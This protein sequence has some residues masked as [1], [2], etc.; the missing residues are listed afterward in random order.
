MKPLHITIVGAGLGGLC[1]AQGLK[2]RGI[3]FDVYERD[4]AL[5]SRTQGYR[6]RIDHAGQQALK[7]CLPAALF[8]VFQSTS[9][10]PV[11]GVNIVDTELEAVSGRWVESWRRARGDA[12]AAAQAEAEA[13][14]QAEAQAE[15][16]SVNRQTL[17]EVLMHG[18]EDR[19]HFGKAFVRYREDEDAR[20]QTGFSDGSSAVSDLLVAADGV[21]SRVRRRRL[22][23]AAPADTGFACLYGKTDPTP[24]TLERLSG[25]LPARTSIVFGGGLAV[26]IDPMRFR[27]PPAGYRL[28]MPGDYLYWA[29]VGARETL[30]I[31]WEAGDALQQDALAARLERI[32]ARWHP[33]LRPL[34]QQSDRASLA[35]APVRTADVPAAWPSSAVTV[36]GDA[37]HAMSPAGGLGANTALHDALLLS[38][39][40]G[41]AAAG[42]RSLRA[43]IG[44]YETAMREYSARAIQASQRGTE[45]LLGVSGRQAER[46]LAG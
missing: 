5:A 42:R 44:G 45:V 29:I 28:N 43:A 9:A 31:G 6:I 20:V 32:T 10:I 21:N 1:L 14:A 36:L 7:G 38:R 22:P 11:G 19:V 4:A 24:A 25:L 23:D 17:R 2:Q 18:I 3:A 37:I 12:P 16:L 15:D 26:I 46:V 34:F 30:G 40:L 41:E 33:G 35:M 8:G 27:P 13:E 39:Q